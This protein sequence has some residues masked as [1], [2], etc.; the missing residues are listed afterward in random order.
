MLGINNS[1]EQVSLGKKMSGGLSVE[2]R[3]QDYR[4]VTG[5]FDRI[6][7]IGMFEHVGPRNYRAFMPSA[8]PGGIVP[9]ISQWLRRWR[10]C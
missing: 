7:S 1:E 2:I 6:V 10:D 4:E 5:V 8:H 3:F 9:T